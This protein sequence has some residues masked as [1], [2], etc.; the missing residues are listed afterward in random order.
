MKLKIFYLVAFVFFPCMAIADGA[1]STMASVLSE[2]S[3]FPSATDKEAL[4]G[5]VEDASSTTD[6]KML[7]QII[8]RIAHKA[9]AADKAELQKILARE[10]TSQAAR[11]IATAVVNIN[12]KLQSDDMQALKALID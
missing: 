7:A 9:S 8:S 10:E 1:I 2:L 4:T 6:E 3:H 5:I 11:A 12:H